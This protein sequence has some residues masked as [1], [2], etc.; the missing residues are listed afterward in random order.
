MGKRW[1]N[2]NYD[3]KGGCA[4]A[5]V[6]RQADKVTTFNGLDDFVCG[7]G[8]I[9][10]KYWYLMRMYIL[11][12]MH[13]YIYIYISILVNLQPRTCDACTL[14][15]LLPSDAATGGPPSP[16]ALLANQIN[17]NVLCLP[18]PPICFYLLR[19]F[20]R[21]ETTTHFREVKHMLMTIVFT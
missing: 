14:A 5:W 16:H 20:F 15:T 1:E 12:R 8:P 10:Q 7:L 2:G 11:M 21:R 19:K 17:S 3:G 13:I 18:L 4:R 9:L 6:W